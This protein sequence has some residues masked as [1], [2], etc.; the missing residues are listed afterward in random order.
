MHVLSVANLLQTHGFLPP[1]LQFLRPDEHQYTALLM[2][3]RGPIFASAHRIGP[4]DSALAAAKGRKFLELARARNAHLAVTPEYYLPWSMLRDAITGGITPPADA[5]WV[6]GSESIT[7]DRLEQFK[8]DVA[9]HCLVLHE[10]WENLTRDRSLLDPAVL[11]FQA[12]KPDQSTHLVAL[13]QFKTYP[14]R[15]DTFFEETLLRT[16]KQIYKFSG[17]SGHLSAAAIICSDAFAAE[18]P[19]LGELNYQST[20]IHVQLNPSPTHSVY[21]NYRTTT[22]ETDAKA[23]NCHIVCLN[24]AHQVEEVNDQGAPKPWKNIAAST[25]YCPKDECSSKD[26]IVTANHRLGL[27]YTY[28]SERRHALRFH[29]EEAT[30]ELLVPKL[31][32]LTKAIMANHNGPSMVDRRVWD[33]AAQDWISGPVPAIDGSAAYVA[34]YPEVNAALTHVLAANDPLAIERVLALSTGDISGRETWHSLESIDSCTIEPDEV[35]RRISVVQDVLGNDF[36]Y[37]R[38]SAIAEIHHEIANQ[39]QWP[40]QVA[41]LDEQSAV[42]WSLAE[43]N[44]NVRTSSGTPTLVVYLDE[45]HSPSKRATKADKLYDLL[46]KAGGQHQQRLCIIRREHGQLQFVQIPALTRFDEASLDQT[47][48]TAIHPLE[49]QEPSN[50]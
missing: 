3:P 31:M 23:T 47:E 37:R 27:Y 44:F 34:A 2:Q 1:D 45:T 24:W 28:M 33:A 4:A 20:I 41:G 8:Q 29:Y 38:I 50:G 11:L 35:V 14:S 40:K 7:Q 5:L 12:R 16:G 30:F 9:S 46:R 18:P 48:F 17:K 22:F 6:L 13:V 21:R 19:V 15:D 26:G 39:T 49:S 42:Q 10:P 43:P 36:R 25:W 32:R